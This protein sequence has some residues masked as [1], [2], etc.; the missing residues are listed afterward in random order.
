MVHRYSCISS[1][2]FAKNGFF[3]IVWHWRR[4]AL[5]QSLE[6]RRITACSKTVEQYEVLF[7]QDEEARRPSRY[8]APYAVQV[9]VLLAHGPLYS[10]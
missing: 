10:P 7:K 1:I 5:L 6:L 9:A 4:S 8:Q 2:Q 3:S